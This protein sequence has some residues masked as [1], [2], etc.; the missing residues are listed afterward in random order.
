MPQSRNQPNSPEQNG[1]SGEMTPVAR[2]AQWTSR[3]MTIS[4]EMVLPGLAGYWLDQKFG[5]RALFMLIGFAVGGIAAFG[6]LIH[7]AR[8]VQNSQNRRN[9]NSVQEN[10]GNEKQ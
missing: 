10:E 2:A 5:T 3:I 9:K 7:L 4:L 8:R 1:F 6:H